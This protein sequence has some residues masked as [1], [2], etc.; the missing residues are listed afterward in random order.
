MKS[1]DQDQPMSFAAPITPKIPAPAPIAP[2]IPIEAILSK[3]PLPEQPPTPK[4]D[5][6]SPVM[7]SIT[8]QPPVPTIQS[9]PPSTPKRTRHDLPVF[10]AT[11]PIFFGDP[12]GGALGN[13]T[14][15]GV[16]MHTRIEQRAT[17]SAQLS[18]ANPALHESI[19][20]RKSDF[21]TQQAPNDATA[22]EV[23]LE[24]ASE[25]SIWDIPET[26]ESQRK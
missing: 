8:D 2:F 23:K 18:G 17:P 19:A 26:P 7:P 14:A 16:D 1:N 3:D 24:K 15:L 6:G 20:P 5:H 9:P 11:S 10:S 22:A 13:D 21:P 4:I 12:K 25:A